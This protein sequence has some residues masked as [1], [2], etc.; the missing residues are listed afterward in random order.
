MGHLLYHFLARDDHLFY[1]FR[2]LF[3]GR[4][5]IITLYGSRVRLISPSDLACAHV[6]VRACECVSSYRDIY[7]FFRHKSV[8]I[9]PFSKGIGSSVGMLPYNG[10]GDG[11]RG[12]GCKQLG[13]SARGF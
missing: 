11:R 5:G 12:G 2:T 10:G 4:N 8:L 7:C 9:H 1:R 3:R 6:R 13:T